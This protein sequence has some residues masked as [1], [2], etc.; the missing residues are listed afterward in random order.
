MYNE[1]AKRIPKNIKKN[2]NNMS[3]KEQPP[4]TSAY[5][6]AAEY[7]DD[8]T[9]SPA[10]LAAAKA[11]RDAARAVWLASDEERNWHV[12]GDAWGGDGG[13]TVS[14]V[15]PSEIEERLADDCRLYG[16]WG[17]NRTETLFVNDWATPIDP[18]TDEP[19]ERERVDVTTTIE[20]DGKSE[21]WIADRRDAEMIEACPYVVDASDRY[22]CGIYYL[23]VSVTS[24]ADDDPLDEIRA[25]IGKKWAVEWYA[26]C[27]TNSEGDR[28]RN[29]EIQWSGS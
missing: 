14:A 5:I 13:D 28:I 8:T 17:E 26:E 1:K 12:G 24:D 21:Q 7:A 18:V 11:L 9:L 6:A 2:E 16:E 22:S 15:C 23:D 25:A 4:A 20:A 3:T 27:E 29:V 10:I 19:I